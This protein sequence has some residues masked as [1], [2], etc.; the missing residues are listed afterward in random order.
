MHNSSPAAEAEF[1]FAVCRLERVTLSGAHVWYVLRRR[2]THRAAA[3][4]AGDFDQVRRLRKHMYV[5]DTRE[6]W[7]GP[8]FDKRPHWC[9]RPGDPDYVRHAWD[10]R[11]A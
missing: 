8:T 2:D 10:T 6:P 9:I 4:V 5:W 7:A 11:P 3:H 1:R